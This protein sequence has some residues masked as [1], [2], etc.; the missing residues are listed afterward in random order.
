MKKIFTCEEC[1]KS[2]PTKHGLIMHTNGIH[3]QKYRYFC[4]VDGCK[5]VFKWASSLRAH[6]KAHKRAESSALIDRINDEML[7]E[8]QSLVP[9]PPKPPE[10]SDFPA[11]QPFSLIET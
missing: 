4:Q 3:L 5:A 7:K 1:G 6:R 9:L 10:D 11:G 2:F 8:R